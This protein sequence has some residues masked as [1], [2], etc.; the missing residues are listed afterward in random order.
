LLRV[1]AR[2]WY[3]C[4][5]V[6]SRRQP[7]PATDSESPGEEVCQENVG[8]GQERW[9]GWASS[10]L[11]GT[12]EEGRRVRAFILPQEVAH[13]AGGVARRQEASHVDGPKLRFT[14]KGQAGL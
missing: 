5:A 7:Q 11:Q 9:R 3:I 2:L 1:S 13:V 4:W 14:V 8:G 10:R 6:P 12:R